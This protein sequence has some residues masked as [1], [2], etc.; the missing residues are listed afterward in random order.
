[1]EAA[2]ETAA[3]FSNWLF[4]K[5]NIKTYY[6]SLGNAAHVQTYTA[7]K[8]KKDV[9]HEKNYGYTLINYG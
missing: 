5:I 3:F 2:V 4:E 8:N 7:L 1:M 9:F 6:G